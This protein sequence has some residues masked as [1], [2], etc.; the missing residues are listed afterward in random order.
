MAQR[1]SSRLEVLVPGWE[2]AQHRG[3]VGVVYPL[4]PRPS[5]DPII[6]VGREEAV[7]VE[8]PALMLTA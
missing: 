6:V 2:G 8:P 3:R 4:Y 1:R 7:A 5:V